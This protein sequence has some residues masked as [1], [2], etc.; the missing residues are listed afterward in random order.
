MPEGKLHE[1]K[2]EPENA[3]VVQGGKQ[4]FRARCYDDKGN[5]VRRVKVKWSVS[6]NIGK[7][8]EKGVFTALTI[9]VGKVSCECTKE[10][11]TKYADTTVSVITPGFPRAS[12][13]EHEEE[14][15]VENVGEIPIEGLPPEYPGKPHPFPGPIG[16][17]DEKI[18]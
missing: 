7:I 15:A 12:A 16:E 3:V 10:D 5:L 8:D 13:P 6:G 1:V 4:K 17:K 11:V 9:G 18:K 2:I 14:H